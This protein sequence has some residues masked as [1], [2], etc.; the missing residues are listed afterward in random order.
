[1]SRQVKEIICKELTAALNGV[2]AAIVIDPTALDGITGNTL[3]R[4]L[5]AAKIRVQLVKNS[6][7]KRAIVGT[8][9]EPVGSLLE[10]ACALAWGGDSIVDVAKLLVAKVKALPKLIIKGAV[11]EGNVLDAAQAA[12][13]SKMPTKAELKSA[14]AAATLSPGRKLAAAILAAGSKIASQLKSRIEALEKTEP[15]APPAAPAPAAA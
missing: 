9:L 7:A 10:G 2:D 3:R 14:L 1:M 11:M 5:A 8:K 15:A 4:D 12:E 6:L 13:L